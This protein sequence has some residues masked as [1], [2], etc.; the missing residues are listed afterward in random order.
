MAEMVK[1]TNCEGMTAVGKKRR[2]S[3]PVSVSRSLRAYSPD[4]AS[5]RCSALLSIAICTNAV[6]TNT[7][8]S[9]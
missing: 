5:N 1:K 6:P 8:T 2:Q 7:T 3:Q 4:L 9:A